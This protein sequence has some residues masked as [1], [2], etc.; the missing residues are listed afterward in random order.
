MKQILSN[1]LKIVFEEVDEIVERDSFSR[2]SG[3][4]DRLL[5]QGESSRIVELGRRLRRVP[6]NPTHDPFRDEVS[7]DLDDLQLGN[8]INFNIVRNMILLLPRSITVIVKLIFFFLHL[9]TN[10]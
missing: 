3:D 8:V 5:L 1:L 7:I 2:K 10:N 6:T 4:E 9:G